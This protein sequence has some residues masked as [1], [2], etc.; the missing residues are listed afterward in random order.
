MLLYI[1]N[2]LENCINVQLVLN[3]FFGKSGG[4]VKSIRKKPKSSPG[5]F[6]FIIIWCKRKNIQTIVCPLTYLLM[7]KVTKYFTVKFFVVL[8]G[9]RT[10]LACQK[11][12]ESP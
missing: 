11:S 5:K 4:M 7:K 8:K 9:K 6:T 2:V 3:V 10:T 12:Q 1:Y